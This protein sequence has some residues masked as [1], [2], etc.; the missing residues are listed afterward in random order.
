MSDPLEAMWSEALTQEPDGVN[1]TAC[2][3]CSEPL[4]PVADPSG[5]VRQWLHLADFPGGPGTDHLAVPAD[6]G[7]LEST[8]LVC[9]FCTA[10]NPT[11]VLPADAFVVSE[12]NAWMPGRNMS[13]DW[14]CCAPCAKALR[15]GNWAMV[16]ERTI[17]ALGAKYRIDSSSQQ[18]TDS[19][20]A[21]HAQVREYQR[22]P[23][24]KAGSAE[25]AG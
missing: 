23:V 14:S 12:A 15:R 9:D 4:A 17:R 21:L 20:K 16:T 2:A 3:V 1:T 13:A 25:P 7:D 18:F 19:L 8:A 24:R 11:W 6:R 22:G 5:H 10:A